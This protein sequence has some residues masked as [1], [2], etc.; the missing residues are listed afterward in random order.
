MYDLILDTYYLPR[1][2]RFKRFKG[3]NVGVVI[4]IKVNE[5]LLEAD[6]CVVRPFSVGF[7]SV[8]V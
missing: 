8:P 2:I 3:S 7:L 5:V 6:V 4:N 1:V